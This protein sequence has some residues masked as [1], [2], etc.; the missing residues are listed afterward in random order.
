MSFIRNRRVAQEP[1]SGSNM[2]RSMDSDRRK[3][4]AGRFWRSTNERH[5]LVLVESSTG[6]MEPKLWEKENG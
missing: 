1:F 2:R 5:K 4:I 3:E 6:H